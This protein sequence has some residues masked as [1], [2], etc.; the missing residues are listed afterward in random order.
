L[1]G[2]R[3]EVD[4]G[5]L[6]AKR[7]RFVGSMLRS[8][9]REEKAA[10]VARFRSELLPAFDSGALRVTVDSTFPPERAAEA[11][12][13]MRDNRNVGKILIPWRRS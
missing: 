11:F 3:V 13:R 6:M 12:Q 2:A 1:A 8:R 7:A 5:L 10:L 4:L 9:S